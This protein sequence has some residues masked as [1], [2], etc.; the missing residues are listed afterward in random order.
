MRSTV[1]TVVATIDLGGTNLRAASVA[2]T[3]DSCRVL[4][5]VRV[6]TSDFVADQNVA[7]SLKAVLNFICEYAES[8]RARFGTEALAAAFPGP[9]QAPGTVL[10]MPTIWGAGGQVLCPFD[11][12]GELAA[13]LPGM[14][15]DVMND[16]SAACYR[17]AGEGDDF[18]LFTLGTGIG[19]KVFIAG[20]PY[21]GP[22]GYGG[23]LTHMVFDRSPEAPL[24]DCGGQGHLGAL[25]SGRAWQ[26]E[27]A[28]S[29][30]SGRE[31][32]LIRFV[33]PLARSVAMLH[34][35]LG[36]ERF[37]FAGGLAE[38]LGES[39]REAIVRNLPAQGWDAG[40]DWDAMIELAPSDDSHAL[41]G[42]ALA[43]ARG[44]Q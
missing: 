31:P 17:F 7:A 4:D 29:R 37:V 20:R 11:L 41:I 16:V 5:V 21:V 12:R 38:G 32:D 23:E 34:F 13:R 26:R 2:V 19:L 44:C 10:A 40:Q 35:S 28:V 9:V 24:C 22:H 27:L 25:S 14:R 43:V 42:G 1:D 18:A 15:I 6:R 3:G 8:S 33:E 30:A 39:L 36:L